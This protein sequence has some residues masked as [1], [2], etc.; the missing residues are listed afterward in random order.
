MPRYKLVIA[1]EGTHFCGWQ[2]QFPHADSVPT[3]PRL[4]PLPPELEHR[5]MDDVGPVGEGGEVRARVELRTVQG[6]LERAV[7]TAIRQRVEVFGASRTDSGVHA[8]GQVA[9]FTCLGEE[10][11][12]AGMG[13]PATR[14]TDAL[15]RA[16]NAKL[17]DD[18]LVR[19]AELVD[20]A[21]DPV[22]GAVSKQYA[23]RLWCGPDRPLWERKRV[24]H[25]WHDI[26]HT[27]MA[28][29]AQEFLGEHDFAGF[30][31]AGHGRKTT[32][33]TVHAC[34][35]QRE[36]TNA[37]SE[38][39]A[40]MPSPLI[41]V[42][43]SGNGFLWNMVRIM[44]GTLVEVGKGKLD[45]ERIRACLR[46]GDRLLAGPTLPGHGL[47]LEWIRYAEPATAPQS[48]TGHS[49]ESA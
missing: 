48:A 19:S 17:P 23:Y 26:D 12:S 7:A 38:A 9:A 40:S 44:V 5:R 41:T 31:A 1:Y 37:A 15:V 10:G 13:W 18:V 36:V 43:V 4:E 2:K 35:V 46:T 24:L 25:L 20:D 47:T 3:A 11:L 14:S 45:R 34:S 6:V 29:A 8:E 32:I 42:R 16:I 33:R 49:A 21:F 39:G 30:A 28:D 22:T 27:L